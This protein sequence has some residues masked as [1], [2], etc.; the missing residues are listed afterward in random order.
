[1]EVRTPIEIVPLKLVVIEIVEWEPVWKFSV[2][3]H[4]RIV[5][6]TRDELAKNY[7]MQYLSWLIERSFPRFRL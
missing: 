1:M 2:L 6:M 5:F 7:P 4:D 3:L